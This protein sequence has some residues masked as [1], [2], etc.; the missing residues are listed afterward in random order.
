[1]TK[2]IVAFRI[3]AEALKHD[4]SVSYMGTESRLAD[5]LVLNTCVCS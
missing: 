2:L 1:M 4:L 5:T 3:F